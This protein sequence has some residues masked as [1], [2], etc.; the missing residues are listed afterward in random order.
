MS[1]FY[2]DACGHPHRIGVACA[3]ENCGCHHTKSPTLG[4][5]GPAPVQRPGPGM[6]REGEFKIAALNAEA[7]DPST[8]LGSLMGAMRE[9][10]PSCLQC[11]KD[12]TVPN[13]NCEHHMHRE[14]NGISPASYA[15]GHRD[16]RWMAMVMVVEAARL[17]DRHAV[18]DP[19]SPT[20]THVPLADIKAL[21]EALARLDMAREGT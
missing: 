5:P 10:S 11:G 8:E 21:H 20:E 2:C 16:P 3:V 19:R 6:A 17:I 14:S 15:P 7:A 9:A 1:A 12:D 13:V 4:R 18:T